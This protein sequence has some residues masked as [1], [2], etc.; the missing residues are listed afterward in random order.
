MS[1]FPRRQFTHALALSV[2]ATHELAAREVAVRGTATG[3]AEP[4][5]F[6][7]AGLKK[8]EKR[9]LFVPPERL[10]AHFAELFGNRAIAKRGVTLSLPALAENGNS[11]ALGLNIDNRSTESSVEHVYVFAEKN[12]L[13][14][15]ARF[16]LS[17]QQ[18]I[19]DSAITELALRIRLA[20]SQQII[21]VA[22][23]QTGMLYA[24]VASIIVTLAACIDIPQ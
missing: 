19:T 2:F 5:R 12:P 4:A 11:V 24:G 15:V 21:A 14:D 1:N 7:K 10:S 3:A 9:E 6:G 20:D 17:P 16:R 13:P 18:T 23:T 22:E 8:S